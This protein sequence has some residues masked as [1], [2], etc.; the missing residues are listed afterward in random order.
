MQVVLC[1][2]GRLRSGAASVCRRPFGHRPRM[3]PKHQFSVLPRPPKVSSTSSLLGICTS[4]NLITFCL[5]DDQC[6]WT[7]LP[8]S[9]PRTTDITTGRY[10][11]HPCNPWGFDAIG[12]PSGRSN[13][14]S[15]PRS[16]LIVHS[17]KQRRRALRGSSGRDI[18]GPS[19]MLITKL[20]GRARPGQ[21]VVT[22]RG[23]KTG[24]RSQTH[25]PLSMHDLIQVRHRCLFRRQCFPIKL[26]QP[27][28]PFTIAKS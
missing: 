13:Q 11:T 4:A 26:L 8:L 20:F 19:K 27:T 23:A 2:P 1:R 9:P 25:R 15:S 28:Y 12:K 7:S 16:I 24:L 5:V 14:H 22:K 6:V 10:V 18:D 21:A 17:V 3:P